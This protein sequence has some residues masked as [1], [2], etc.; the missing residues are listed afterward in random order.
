MNRVFIDLQSSYGPCPPLQGGK[1]RN[2]RTEPLTTSKKQTRVFAFV[3]FTSLRGRNAG[4]LLWCRAL[5]VLPSGG[6]A[7]AGSPAG[8]AASREA[9]PARNGSD[10]PSGPG[11]LSDHLPT[12]QKIHKIQ[13]Q[14]AVPGSWNHSSRVHIT[15]D[16]YTDRYRKLNK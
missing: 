12:V 8:R 1:R 13:H 9:A 5:T 15:H 2:L 16:A 14:N 3:Y 7:A 6:A 10:P 11:G 4:N